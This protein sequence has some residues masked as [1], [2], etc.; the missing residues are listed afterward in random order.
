M[1]V[2]SSVQGIQGLCFS[3]CFLPQYRIQHIRKNTSGSKMLPLKTS[4][5]FAL[6]ALFFLPYKAWVPQGERTHWLFARS[7]ATSRLGQGTIPQDQKQGVQALWWVSV[8]MRGESGQT[9]WVAPRCHWINLCAIDHWSPGCII[10]LLLL[11][12]EGKSFRGDLLRPKKMYVD[13]R[14]G[15]TE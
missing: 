3:L 8:G 12:L 6:P 14:R 1:Q 10:H 5:L 15:N 13:S 7:L 4:A 9:R 11:T 2:L